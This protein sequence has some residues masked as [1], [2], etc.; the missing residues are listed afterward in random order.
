M[1]EGSGFKVDDVVG[2]SDI[3]IEE[4]RLYRISSR[5]RSKHTSSSEVVNQIK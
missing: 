2:A 4:Y 5:S 3:E 1:I